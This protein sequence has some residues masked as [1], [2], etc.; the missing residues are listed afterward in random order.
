MVVAGRTLLAAGTPDVLD[1]AQPWAAYEAR[2]GGV[3]LAIAT[4]DGSVTARVQLDAAPV[5]DGLCVYRGALVVAT[6]DGCIRCLK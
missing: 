6:V 5:L 1:P 2:R 4:A 3:L